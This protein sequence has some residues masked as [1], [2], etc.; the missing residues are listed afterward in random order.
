[1]PAKKIIEAVG[2]TCV[3]IGSS[4]ATVTAGP[5]PGSTPTPVP[6]AQPMKAHSRLIGV[7]A[8]AKPPSNWFQVSIMAASSD[9]ARGGDAGQV[10]R[11]Q[12]GEHPEHRRG[13]READEEVDDRLP[14]A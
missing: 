7:A 6:T 3:V 14:D 1:M 9:P 2:S 10:D 4:I 11:E 8:V 13:D 5:S 12:F